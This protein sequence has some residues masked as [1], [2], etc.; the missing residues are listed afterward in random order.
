MASFC[1]AFHDF[2][3]EW[4]GASIDGLLTR[5]GSLCSGG[6]PGSSLKKEKACTRQ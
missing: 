5:G 2:I 6:E 1:A 3:Q 4:M